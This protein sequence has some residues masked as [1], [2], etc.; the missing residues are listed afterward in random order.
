MITANVDLNIGVNIIDTKYMIHVFLAG[1]RPLAE[2]ALSLSQN[3]I[4]MKLEGGIR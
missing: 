3:G 1:P 2:D 4:G